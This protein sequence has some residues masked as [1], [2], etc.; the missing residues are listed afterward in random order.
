MTVAASS[1]LELRCRLC[2]DTTEFRYRGLEEWAVTGELAPSSHEVGV[3]GDLYVCRRCGTVQPGELPPQEV[4]SARYAETDDERYLDE[5]P[6]RRRTAGRLLDLI[7]RR[8]AIGRLL[9]VGC[10]H[11]LLMD[12]ARRR[13]WRVTGLELSRSS[14]AH[15][16]RLGL[17]IREQAIEEAGFPPK[18]FD[19]VVAVDLIEH[20]HQ[21]RDFVRRCAELLVPGGALLIATP[22]PESPLAR[23][24]GRRWWGYIPSHL[25]LL[26]RRMLRELLQ[27]EG[28]LLA[29]DVPMVRDFSFGYWLA[30]F[31]GRARW[32]AVA[33]HRIQRSRRSERS[34]SVSLGDERVVVAQRPKLLAP[35]KPLAH[36]AD[37]KPTV[38]AVLPA[39][40]AAATLSE[41]ARQLPGAAV[42]RAIV[43]DDASPDSTTEV[44][45]EN[46][47]EVIRH[48]ANRGYGANQKTCYVHALRSG[49]D[50][51]VM[52][53]ADNQYD[54]R[55]VPEMIEPIIKGRADVVIGSRML[56][57]RAI[58]GG[59]P[60]WKWIGNK[61]LTWIENQ[62]FRRQ[63]S[64]Y[65]T[66]YRA[67][68]ADFLRSVAFLRNS[69]AFVFDQEIFAQATARHALVEEVAIPT[70]Y[71]LEASSV[72]FKESV[73]YGLRTLVLLGRFRAH[74]AG[75]V[76]W[77]LLGAPAFEL[78]AR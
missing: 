49:A 34:L 51:V 1:D 31:A 15:A 33:V 22:D 25:H 73:R 38:Y 12:E 72:S 62:G 29:D 2:G 64:E 11:G 52:V 24:F 55:L 58:I 19:A 8:F 48:P 5:E 23:V 44:A 47:F 60:R 21:P 78:G 4:M 43:V 59:M 13:G 16:R 42:N 30:G 50:V 7:E 45:V 39:Y 6:G 63:Y 3:H 75:L 27:A 41:V 14:A 18:S 35:A 56:D 32:A 71:F 77:P 70:R 54:P 66:G 28:L 53:H 20:L 76:R 17:D 26:P 9:D 36:R 65:H 46:G 57:D 40:R 69:D 67:F 37:Q 10:G 74:D 68:S 61:L